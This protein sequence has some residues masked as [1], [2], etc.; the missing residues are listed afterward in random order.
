VTPF[1]PKR[2]YLENTVA[3]IE[4]KPQHVQVQNG[5]LTFKDGRVRLDPFSPDYYSLHASP[6]A[7]DP[8]A[9][10]PKFEA[11]LAHLDPDDIDVIQRAAG[12][13]LL[14]RNL[15]Q[16]IFLFEGV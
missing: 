16:K 3:F 4:K 7:Y 15:A 1:A 11:L 2:G 9:K 10:C 14:G 13:F 8:D 12:M 5:V 6:L